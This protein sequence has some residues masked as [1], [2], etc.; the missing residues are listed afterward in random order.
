ME[1][2]M[3]KKVVDVPIYQLKVTLEESKPPIWRRL[4]VRSD[5]TLATLHDILQAAFGW[6]ESHLHQFI[7]GG[8]Y[9]GEP[10]PD[11]G[12]DDMKDERKVKLNQV[13]QQEK[14]SFRYEYDFGDGWMHRIVLEKIV[15][16]EAGQ[17]YP[18]CVTG[19]RAG[20]PEDVGG[21][22]GYYNFLEAISDPEHEE[23]DDY[24]EWIADEW[25]PEEFDLEEINGQLKG[26]SRQ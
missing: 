17:H 8:T 19:R 7:V 21:M 10:H 14:G 25:D 6:T 5:V 3:A 9:Y 12:M 23:H 1:V 13:L 11:Y 16:P 26:L 15:A 18:V 2:E 4:L 24:V 22:W 20:P